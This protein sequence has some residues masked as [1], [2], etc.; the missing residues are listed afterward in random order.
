MRSLFRS[1]ERDGLEYLLISG[2][3]SVLY[4]AATFSEDVDIW[5]RPKVANLRR[6]LS[7]LGARRARVHKLTPPL[8]LR[9]ANAGHGFHFIVPGT[10]LPVYL[11]VMAR[12]PRVGSFEGAM[13]R[14][15]RLP[16]DWGVLPVVGIE[17]LVAL[18]KTRRWADYDVISNLAR[19]RLA[20][21]GS[22][23]SRALLRWTA[24][25]CFRAEERVALLSRMSERRSIDACRDDI[26]REIARLQAMDVRYWKPRIDK[27][28]KLRRSGSLWPEGVPVSTMLKTK[29][30]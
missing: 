29:V 23:P 6:L 21:A 4:G 7:S 20:E 3:A 15:Q 11:D 25:H 28:R 26:L 14:A 1:F 9:Y 2:Q 5:V 19:V 12:P 10:P 8:T 18:K 13:S 30:S 17:D 27:L 24:R 16:T 22:A